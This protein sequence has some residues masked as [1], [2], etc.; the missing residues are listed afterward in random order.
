MEKNKIINIK[1]NFIKKKIFFNNELKKMILKSII[2]NKNIK[3]IIRSFSF[4]KLSK[5]KYINNISKQNNNIC[6]YTGR[7]KGVFSYYKMSRHLIKKKCF[8]NE[9]QSTKL[10]N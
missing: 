5:L 7:I 10:I 1:K 6:I 9:I 2:Q 3:P 8:E 4:Y